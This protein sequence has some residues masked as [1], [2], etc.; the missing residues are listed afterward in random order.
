MAHEFY[1]F[2]LINYFTAHLALVCRFRAFIF[3]V[4]SVIGVAIWTF[5]NPL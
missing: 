3:E 5:D 4:D 2:E 1:L